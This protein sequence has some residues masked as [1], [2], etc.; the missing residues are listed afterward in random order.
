M[1]ACA[2]RKSLGR[3]RQAVF[4]C[5][6]GAGKETGACGAAGVATWAWLAK[7]RILS[8]GT[9]TVT[10]TC[11]ISTFRGAKAATQLALSPTGN[12]PVPFRPS[13]NRLA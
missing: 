10:P 12:V 1:V 2:R 3:E 6:A 5:W 11:H 9:Y 8:R 4:H 13:G 7:T